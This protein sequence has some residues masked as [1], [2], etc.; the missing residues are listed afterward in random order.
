M[1]PGEQLP[2]FDAPAS[3]MRRTAPAPRSSTVRYTRIA[4][5]GLRLCRDC[6][7]AIYQHRSR[8]RRAPAPKRATWRRTDDTTDLVLCQDHK[9]QRH[10]D[11]HR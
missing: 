2:L 10:A 4:A 1:T 9:E 5:N 7:T 8:G 3:P 11:D 6:C